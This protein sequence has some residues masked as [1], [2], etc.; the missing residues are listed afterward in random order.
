M[1]RDKFIRK[2]LAMVG[3]LRVQACVAELVSLLTAL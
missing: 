2:A 3:N 1:I